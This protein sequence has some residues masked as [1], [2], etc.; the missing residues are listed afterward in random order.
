MAEFSLAGALS[1]Q[2]YCVL[3][4][5][6]RISAAFLMLPGYGEPSLPTRIRL[7]AAL[8]V[9]AAVAPA[10]TGMPLVVPPVL[11]IAMAVAAEV[12]CGALLGS[13]SRTVISGVL[14]GGQVI[15]QNIGLTNILQPG[16]ALDD[17]TTVGA[18]FY[19]GILAILFASNGHQVILRT[20]V[21]SYN[22]LPPAQFPD[23]SASLRSMVAAGVQCIRLGG[24]LALPFLLLA[25]LFNASLAAVNRAMQAM[26]VFMIFAPSLVLLGLY[27][28]AATVPAILEASMG[29]WTDLVQLLH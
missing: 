6:T 18:A 23:V 19:A 17:A 8:A 26:P 15:S 4:V 9:A 7:L 13:L 3:L 25:L 28:L 10:V 16:L 11:R 12:V 29:G 21:D 1:L 14:L 5:F 22:V 24:Q 27:L 2:I 20:L